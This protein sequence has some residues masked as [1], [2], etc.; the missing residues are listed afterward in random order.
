MFDARDPTARSDV[1]RV[2]IVLILFALIILGVI[3]HIELELQY[4]N[5]RLD[6][7][8]A[9]PSPTVLPIEQTQQ[10]HDHDTSPKLPEVG[11]AI[12]IACLVRRILRPYTIARPAPR[13]S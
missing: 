4:I 9:N 11:A 8:T 13:V 5:E 2:L 3:I 1:L 6:A 10:L 12:A 7:L